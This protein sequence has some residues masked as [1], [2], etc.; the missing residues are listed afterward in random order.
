MLRI[1]IITMTDFKHKRP[2]NFR[3]EYMKVGSLLYIYLIVGYIG[4]VQ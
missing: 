4:Q 2:R 3:A 1:P